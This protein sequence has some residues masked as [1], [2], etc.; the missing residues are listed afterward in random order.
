MHTV[1]EQWIR[2]HATAKGGWKKRQLE[3]IGEPWPPKPGWIARAVGRQI[4]E[5]QR[6]EFE[7]MVAGR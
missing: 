7:S 1:T 5:D 3:L 6:L 2:D 4:T